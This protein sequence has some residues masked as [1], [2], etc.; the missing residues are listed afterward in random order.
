MKCIITFNY[1]D[2]MNLINPEDVSLLS[3]IQSPSGDEFTRPVTPPVADAVGSR[4]TTITDTALNP[5]SLYVRK[6][7]VQPDGGKTSFLGKQILARGVRLVLTPASLITCALDTIIGFGTG[8]VA[9][10]KHGTDEKMN[11]LA[12]SHFS[13]TNLLLS[14]PYRHL[15]GIINP[16]AEFPLRCQT[17]G[18]AV[19]GNGFISDIV[20]RPLKT[21]AEDFR[22]SKN[23]VSKHVASRLTYALLGIASIVT[24]LF[25]LVIGIPAAA[26]SLVT[27]GKFGTLNN[28]AFRSLQV[29]GIVGDLFF[30][31]IKIVNPDAVIPEKNR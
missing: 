31:T 11:K 24:K 20:S 13:K 22:S 6:H 25:D 10:L 7:L 26:L 12:F 9:L 19:E 8:V 5:V 30:A 28:L 29:T 2:K 3:G 17:R 14:S 21:L 18:I 15:L 16:E 1:G 4:Y 23:F 27:L